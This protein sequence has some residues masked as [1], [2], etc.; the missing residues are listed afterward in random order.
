MSVQKQQKHLPSNLKQWKDL[1]QATREELTAINEIGEKMADSIVTYF[2]QEEVQEL[3][4]ELDRLEL[5]WN[6]KDLNRLSQKNPILSLAGKTVVLTGKL[7]QLTRNEAKE[8]IEALGG[9]VAGS[10]SKKTDL[11]IA[12]EEA[13]SKLKKAEELGIEV[14]NEEKLIE[15]LNKVRGGN[16]EKISSGRSIANPFTDCL[17]SEFS[18]SKRK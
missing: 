2:E 14:W 13:G 4:Q 18:K 3:I 1:S 6:I 17:C 8:K 12:G 5:I 16:H 9:N 10:V 11:V 7:E 15:E